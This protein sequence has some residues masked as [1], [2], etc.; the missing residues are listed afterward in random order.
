MTVASEPTFMGSTVKDNTGTTIGRV[1]DVLFDGAMATPTWLVVKP[2]IFRAEHYVP[3]RDAY[4]TVDD[5]VVVPYNRDYVTS[6]PK[7]SRDHVMSKNDRALLAQYFGLD[8]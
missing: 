8:R 4:H 2:G 1:R 6:S 5:E 3:T 7:A